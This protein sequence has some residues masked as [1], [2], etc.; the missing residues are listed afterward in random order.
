MDQEK[1]RLLDAFEGC[2]EY[3]DRLPVEV[4][5]HEGKIETVFVYFIKSFKPDLLEK[6]MLKEYLS[7]GDHGLPYETRFGEGDV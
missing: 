5:V 7:E 1:L 2:P 6:P 3:Y 4:E